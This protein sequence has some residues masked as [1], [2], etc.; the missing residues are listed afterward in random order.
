VKPEGPVRGLRQG[1][2]LI[3]M[4]EF[5]SIHFVSI[6]VATTHFT[7]P[8]LDRATRDFLGGPRNRLRGCGKS[9]VDKKLAHGLVDAGTATGKG[10]LPQPLDQ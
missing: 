6:S 8:H 3:S 1:V 7:R 2:V 4:V 5:T 9:E 10:L